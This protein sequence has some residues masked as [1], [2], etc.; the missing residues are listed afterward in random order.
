GHT[1]PEVGI[2]QSAA[3]THG[4]G[5]AAQ[6]LVAGKGA[7]RDRGGAARVDRSARRE[8]IAGAGRKIRADGDS[9]VRVEAAMADQQRTLQVLDGPARP[10]TG[11]SAKG[12]VVVKRAIA[13]AQGTR[14]VLQDGSPLA[15]QPLG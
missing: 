7:V 15:G 4:S 3:T 11:S 2:V 9:L 8:N 10:T 6:R 1:G 5:A 13:E 14:A 12:L